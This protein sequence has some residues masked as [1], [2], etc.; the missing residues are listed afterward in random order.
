MSKINEL[1]GKYRCKP[2]LCHGDII[3]KI[4]NDSN[5]CVSHKA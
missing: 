2:D 3:I 5:D 4:L 1:R